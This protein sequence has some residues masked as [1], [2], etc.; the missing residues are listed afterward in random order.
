MISASPQWP[1]LADTL[2]LYPT[3]PPGVSGAHLPNK[4]LAL[5]SL[6]QFC[7]RGPKLSQ[8]RTSLIPS[9]LMGLPLLST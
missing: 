6:S 7:I 8:G 3:L 1:W 5:E 2:C 9:H 4:V